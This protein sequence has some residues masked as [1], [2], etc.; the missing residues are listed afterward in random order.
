MEWLYEN[1]AANDTTATDNHGIN[2]FTDA[3]EAGES[4]TKKRAEIKRDAKDVAMYPRPA[5]LC[6]KTL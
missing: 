6:V 1:G 2:P 4:A 5:V 3:C